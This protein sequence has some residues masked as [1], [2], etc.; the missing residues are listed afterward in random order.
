[1]NFSA[2]RFLPAPR[3]WLFAPTDNNV[4]QTTDERQI[5]NVQMVSG[6]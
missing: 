5:H 6:P 1:V 2:S 3:F 4:S